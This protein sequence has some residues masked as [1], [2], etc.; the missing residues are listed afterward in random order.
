MIALLL[1]LLALGGPKAQA[2]T[3]RMVTKQGWTAHCGASVQGQSGGK[4]LRVGHPTWSLHRPVAL[5][6]I[7]P[8]AAEITQGVVFQPV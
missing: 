1:A 4:G 6:R 3:Q 2:E 7:W 5:V 8:D